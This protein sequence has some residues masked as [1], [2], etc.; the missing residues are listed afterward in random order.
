[1]KFEHSAKVVFGIEGCT[2]AELSEAIATLT[3]ELGSGAKVRVHTIAEHQ[4]GGE[5]GGYAVT[6]VS[7][8]HGFVEREVDF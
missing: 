8:I 7:A 6:N 5:Q 3:G 4:L 2:L 1:M